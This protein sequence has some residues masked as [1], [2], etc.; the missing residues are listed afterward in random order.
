MN[1]SP[2]GY[3]LER[4]QEAKGKMF[5]YRYQGEDSQEPDHRLCAPCWNGKNLTVVLH[6]IEVSE[7]RIDLFCPCCDWKAVYR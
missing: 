7:R 1:G 2:K 4:V 6:E 5:A 3:R